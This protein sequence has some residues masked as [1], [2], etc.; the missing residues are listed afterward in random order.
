MPGAFSTAIAQTAIFS[1][2]DNNGAPNAGTYH[3]G[4]SFTFS[5]NLTYAP[6]GSVNNLAGLSYWLQQ[7]SPASPFILSVAGRDVTG[8]QFTFL[9]SPGAV[10]PQAMTPSN[11]SDLGAGTQS[12]NGLGANTY[13]IANVTI[14][15]S[16]TAPITGTYILSQTLTGGRTSVITDMV[17]HTFAIPEVDYTI[18]MVPEPATWAGGAFTVATLVIAGVRRRLYAGRESRGP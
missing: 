2:N 13:F 7:R 15:I 11:S 1:Y 16:P 6:G 9:Q 14:Q 4:D 18:T 3:P 10:F 12:G 17:G 8:S 5:I